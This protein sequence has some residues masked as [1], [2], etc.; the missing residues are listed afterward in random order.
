[1]D[2]NIVTAFDEKEEEPKPTENKPRPY[3][4]WKVGG[5][6]YRLKLTAGVCAK[7]EE[8]FDDSITDAVLDTGLP[9]ISV[10]ISLLQGAMQKFNHG[11]KSQQ[12]ADLL[13]EYFAEGKTQIDLVKEVVYPLMYD[14]GFFTEAMFRTVKKAAEEIDLAL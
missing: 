11:I 14:A 4:I 6:E 13:D 7:L 10:A 3:L 9:K 5:E 12:V 1:M 2:E 8:Q